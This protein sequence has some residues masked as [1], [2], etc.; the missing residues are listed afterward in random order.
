METYI[1]DGDEMNDVF[2]ESFT[3]K[4]SEYFTLAYQEK[5]YGKYAK[6]EREFYRS[7]NH[8]KQSL[9]LWSKSF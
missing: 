9:K 7:T 8:G 4:M 3:S 1:A 5:R 6:F 2:S